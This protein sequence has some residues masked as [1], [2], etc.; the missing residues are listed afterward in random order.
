MSRFKTERGDGMR[1]TIK[2]PYEDMKN[3]TITASMSEEELLHSPKAELMF[4]AAPARPLISTNFEKTREI[5]TENF[6]QSFETL[7]LILAANLAARNFYNFYCVDLGITNEQTKRQKFFL[8]Y[9]EYVAVPPLDGGDGPGE[10]LLFDHYNEV[11]EGHNKA[12]DKIQ[13]LNGQR[14]TQVDHEKH[15]YSIDHKLSVNDIMKDV[16]YWF[17]GVNEDLKSIYDND[18]VVN[19]FRKQVESERQRE[20]LTA[21]KVKHE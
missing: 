17:Q 21:S 20:P 14:F 13:E 3:K 18:F 4:A 19:I 1:A 2:E 5:I 12:I 9:N 8:Y 6:C 10:V 15:I 7:E 16:K 11:I